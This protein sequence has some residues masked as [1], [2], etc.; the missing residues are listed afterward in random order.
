MEIR[1]TKERERCGEARSCE[2]VGGQR[3]RGI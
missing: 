1:L 3:A 2:T